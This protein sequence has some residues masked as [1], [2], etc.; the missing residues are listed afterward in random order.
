MD[1][2]DQLLR[3]LIPVLRSYD[4]VLNEA[5]SVIIPKFALL[6]EEPD[7]EALFSAAVEEI[8]EQVDDDDFD[9]DYGFQSDWEDEEDDDFDGTDEDDEEDEDD[10]EAGDLELKATM[11]LF[12]SIHEYPGNEENIERFACLCFRRRRLTTP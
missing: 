11:V 10:G 4:L 6:S 8:S 12:D 2:A 9:A 7:L 3:E 1:A 5:K